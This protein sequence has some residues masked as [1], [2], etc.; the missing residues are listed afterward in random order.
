MATA[1]TTAEVKGGVPVFHVAEEPHHEGHSTVIGFWMFLMQDMLLFCGLFAIYAWLGGHY[2]NGPAPL[3]DGHG[4]QLFHLPMIAIN[5]I[6]MLLSAFTC[7]IAMVETR[8]KHVG[9]ALKLFGVTAFL[10][11]CFLYNQV[12]EYGHLTALG[13]TYQTSAFLSSFFVIIFTHSLHV[14]AALVWA[15]VLAVQILLRGLD[16]A[17]ERR[18]VCFSMFWNFLDITWVCVF[19]FVYLMG[20]LK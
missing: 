1:S 2:A 13:A 7:S 3:D 14:I 15:A 20:V 16:E 17:N 6:I 18:V 4:G 9:T 10:G 5:T 8:K 11:V 12:T 19:V